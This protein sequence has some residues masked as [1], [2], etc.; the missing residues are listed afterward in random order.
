MAQD[1]NN[2]RELA[3][4]ALHALDAL[5]RSVEG[6]GGWRLLV[7]A[8]GALS[9]YV[10]QGAIPP[11]APITVQPAATGGVT[12]VRGRQH[13]TI[14]DDELDQVREEINARK[15]EIRKRERRAGQRKP[16]E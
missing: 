14:V 16:G 15:R 8:R 6:G 11:D 3:Q 10:Q 2:A 9:G 7:D 4:Q 12:L 13:F 1:K 5:L